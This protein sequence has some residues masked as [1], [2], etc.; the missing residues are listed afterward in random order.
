MSDSTT[1][2]DDIEAALSQA[3]AP[4]APDPA[5]APAEPIA[6]AAAQADDSA[7]A[8]ALAEGQDLDKLAEQPDSQ[9]LQQQR[10]EQGRFKPKAQQQ[11]EPIQPGPK[12]GPRQPGERAPASWRPDVREHWG[13]LPEPVRAEIQ[14]REVEVQRTLQES[15]EARR[16]YD[17]VM[18]TIQPYETFIRAENSNPIQAIDNLMRTAATLRIG[19]PA[20][21]A[22]LLAGVVKQYGVDVNMLDAALAG[23]VPATDP[24]TAA[25]EQ[26]LNQRLAPVQNMLQQF[27]QAQ[28][29]QQQRVTEQAQ[30]EVQKFLEKAEFGQDVR[31]AMAD[32]LELAQRRGQ[33]MTIQEAYRKA[34]LADDR[35]VKVLQG[36]AQA[37]G[38]QTQTQA[39]QRARQAAVSVT[40]AAPAGALKQDPTDVRSAI[41]AAIVM[42][43][44]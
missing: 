36:R 43:S 31:E 20:E 10:D 27:Q 35:I 5:P 30:T 40:G 7:P 13:Q 42:N 37:R 4:A 19:T 44:R 34:C 6:E 15:A 9:T 25:F 21:K 23:Q 8:A 41:E 22:Q 2:R 16:N 12:P 14:R 3:E 28:A 17:A 26:A 33:P 38:A 11:A 1:I 32:L 29:M 24:Q 18:R 39:A